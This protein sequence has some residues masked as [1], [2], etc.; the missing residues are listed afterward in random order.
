MKR[1]ITYLLLCMFV[2]SL[3][4]NTKVKAAGANITFSTKEDIV[5][6]GEKILVSIHVTS[7]VEIGDFETFIS[8][9]S[10]VLEFVEG[11]SFIA[12]GEGLLKLSHTNVLE[13]EKERKYVLEFK[14]TRIG[15]GDIAIE[16][17]PEI[18]D[19]ETNTNMSV[20]SNRMTVEVV[21]E[22]KA[23]SNSN[24]KELKISPSV[25]DFKFEKEKT[26]YKF[27]VENNITKLII[28]AKPEDEKSSVTIDGDINLK[29]GDNLISLV[30]KAES[31]DITTYTL[32]VTRLKGEETG[33]EEEPVLGENAVIGKVEVI[34][35]EETRYIQSG[36]RYQIPEEG[37]TE[38]LIQEYSLQDYKEVSYTIGEMEITAYEKEGEED[39]LLLYLINEAGDMGIYQYDKK[40][41]T[42]QRYTVQPVVEEPDTTPVIEEE[43]ITKEEANSRIKNYRIAVIILSVAV[44]LLAISGI[45]A[46]W[47]YYKQKRNHLK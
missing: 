14:A 41:N 15:K 19:F 34:Q 32:E 45:V 38:E 4:L 42:L 43:M 3:L 7:E 9:N 27:T 21:P 39:F 31:G 40:E 33:E 12:G 28:S 6:K 29:E 47:Y 24:L 35:V 10:D 44:T 25:S 11:N 1:K 13:G 16:G 8:Y 23:S 20:S 2:L 30:V 37:L 17:K 46:L 5:V 18:Y 26:E 36:Y 22:E